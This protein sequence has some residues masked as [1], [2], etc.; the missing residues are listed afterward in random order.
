[1]EKDS[2]VREVDVVRGGTFVGHYLPVHFYI[3]HLRV[4]N[5]KIFGRELCPSSLISAD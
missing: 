5:M 2:T 1:M 4:R 3:G